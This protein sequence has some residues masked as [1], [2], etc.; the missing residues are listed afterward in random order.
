MTEEQKRSQWF[1]VHVLSGREKMVK[2]NIDRRVQMEE[3]SDYIFNVM[4]PEER[5]SEVKQGKRTESKRKSFPGYLFINMWLIDEDKRPDPADPKANLVDRTWYFIQETSNIIGFAGRRDRPSKM[6]PVE[7]EN[8]LKEY[9][10]LSE[11]ARPKMDFQVGEKVKVAD[12]PFMSQSGPVVEVDP[13]KGKLRV[14]VEIFGRA[15][16]V[17]LEYWQVE[18]D[19]GD[20]SK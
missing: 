6:S 10:V 7:V 19:D 4:L 8:L 11:D 20:D 12:G 13:E 14:S 17:D 9:T 15:T 1:V 18:K 3:M 5:V 16:L 2:D